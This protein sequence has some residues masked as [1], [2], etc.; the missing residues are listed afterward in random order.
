L[1]SGKCSD[2]K[3]NQTIQKGD[4][5]CT[6]SP[7]YPTI[8]TTTW[9]PTG[10]ADTPYLPFVTSCGELDAM[11]ECKKHDDDYG[12]CGNGPTPE[13]LQLTADERLRANLKD[14]CVNKAV[15]K[16]DTECVKECKQTADLYYSGVR[17]LGWVLYPDSHRKGCE[18]C[19]D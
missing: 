9:V 3:T 10:N 5:E 17:T 11:T 12:T 2:R 7:N 15:F 14:S 6:S 18:C 8:S 16:G 4:Q 13:Q 19:P 1:E